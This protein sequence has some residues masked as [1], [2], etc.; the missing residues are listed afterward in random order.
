MTQLNAD[1]GP[2]GS[3]RVLSGLGEGKWE[4]DSTGCGLQAPARRL[5]LLFGSQEV[6]ELCRP[7]DTIEVF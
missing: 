3:S 7:L 2:V 1:L 5:L 4:A 6:W